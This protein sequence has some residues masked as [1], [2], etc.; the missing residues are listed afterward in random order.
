ML[1]DLLRPLT[2]AIGALRT[3][4]AAVTVNFVEG[5]G[6]RP[7]DALTAR[8]GVGVRKPSGKE[9]AGGKG[10]ALRLALCGLRCRAGVGQAGRARRCD[11]DRLVTVS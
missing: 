10:A 4:L 8:T 3:M 6:C 1:G 11:C 7:F 2:V 5:Y 9:P